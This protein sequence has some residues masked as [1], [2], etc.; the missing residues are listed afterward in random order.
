MAVQTALRG[1]SVGLDELAPT[2][3]LPVP[4][5]SSRL[6]EG[7]ILDDAAAP[8]DLVRVAL[9]GADGERH[10]QGPCPFMPRGMALPQQGDRCLLALDDDGSPWIVAWEN[11]QADPTLIFAGAA[12]GGDLAGNYP[13]PTLAN[14]AVTVEKLADDTALALFATGTEAAVGAGATVKIATITELHDPGADFSAGGDYTVPVSGF[15]LIYGWVELQNSN[16]DKRGRIS[17][18]LNGAASGRPLA[19]PWVPVA[20]ANVSGGGFSGGVFAANDLISAEV[21]NGDNAARN[22]AW[23]FAIARIT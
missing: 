4:G 5:E 21:Q 15:Y 2:P 12:A 6:W 19:E 8:N 20:G 17:M 18:R 14:A 1:G 10:A 3:T 16:A 11:A 23:R 22:I 7:T 9:P 13:N